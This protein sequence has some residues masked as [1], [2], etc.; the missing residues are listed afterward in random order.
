MISKGQIKLITGLQQKKYRTKAGLFAAEG[1]KVIAELE[2]EGLK[3]HSLFTINDETVQSNNVFKVSELELK[4]ISFLTTANSS[5]A[6]FEIPKTTPLA[7]KGLTVVLDAVRDP[8]NLGTIIRLCDW[9]DVTQLVCSKDTVDCYNP[10][11]VQATMGSI[12]RLPIHYVDLNEFLEN[13]NLPVYAGM[14]DGAS[15]YESALPE[16]AIIVL[17]NEAN[18]VSAEILSKVTARITIP[19]FGIR[20]ATESLNVATATAILLSEFKRSTG[21]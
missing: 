12:A 17:G 3:L 8:G 6:L 15:I 20:Q 1:P 5:L 10:K 7:T 14:M 21:K 4:K 19:Q 2:K 13:A 9:F 16:N 18:G 11:V